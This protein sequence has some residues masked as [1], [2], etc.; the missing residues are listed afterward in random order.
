MDH[1]MKADNELAEMI[2]YHD[3]EAPVGG[4]LYTTTI[5]GASL[6]E[7][8]SLPGDAG[9]NITAL[10][11]VKKIGSNTF[12]YDTGICIQPTRGFYTEL[13][14]RSSIIKSGHMLSN[15]VG[16]LDASF[17]GSIKIVMTKT[18][19]EA[20]DLELPFTLC[21]LIPRRLYAWNAERVETLSDT[22]R[23]GGEFGSTD[24]KLNV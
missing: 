24:E 9:I 1:K 17:S 8:P 22:T 16:I 19:P 14:P 18:D 23:G 15:N 21:Q 3:L 4:I 7:E 6:P 2:R 5:E 12:M 10:E 13:I 20:K 11:F